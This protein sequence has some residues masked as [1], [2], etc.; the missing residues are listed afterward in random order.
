[1]LQCMYKFQKFQALFDV[2]HYCQLF[3]TYSLSFS[4]QGK[5]VMELC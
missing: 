1:M 4:F 5:N 3:F 2:K